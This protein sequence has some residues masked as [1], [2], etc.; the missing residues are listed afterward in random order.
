MRK[1]ITFQ[2][3]HLGGSLFSQQQNDDV[4]ELSV[5]AEGVV[6]YAKTAG[7]QYDTKVLGNFLN[8]KWHVVYLQYTLGNLTINVDGQ[9]KV[10]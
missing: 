3:F 2:L 5:N 8:N 10:F 1:I 6:F 7:K 4:L 9:L